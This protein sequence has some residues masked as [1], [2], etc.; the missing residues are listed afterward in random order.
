MSACSLS[1]TSAVVQINEAKHTLHWMLCAAAFC[2]SWLPA[3]REKAET[4]VRIA[5]ANA[6]ARGA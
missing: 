3:V 1:L 6:D 2:L 4:M 5:A